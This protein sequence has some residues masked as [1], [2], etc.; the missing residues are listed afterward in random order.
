[1]VYRSSEDMFYNQLLHCNIN[2][3]DLFYVGEVINSVQNIGSFNSFS[4]VVKSAYDAA[5]LVATFGYFT[6]NMEF[7][8]KIIDKYGFVLMGVVSFISA[9]VK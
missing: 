9:V 1:M 5:A 3:Y 8:M 6:N 4:E 2:L 7:L